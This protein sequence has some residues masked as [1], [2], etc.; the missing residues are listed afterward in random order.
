L[1]WKKSV[2]DGMECLGIVEVGFGLTTEEV[3]FSLTVK[4]LNGPSGF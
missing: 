3:D 1:E 2:L 4:A